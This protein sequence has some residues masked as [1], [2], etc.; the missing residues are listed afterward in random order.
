M[1]TTHL[2]R[3]AVVALAA[4][5]VALATA[6]GS[7]SAPTASTASATS[8]AAATSAS[9]SPS[10]STTATSAAAPAPGTPTRHATSAAPTQSHS[11][12]ATTPAGGVVL[13]TSAGDYGQGL[14][15]AWAARDK[16]AMGTYATPAVVAQLSAAK[17]PSKLLRTACEGDMCSW[18]NE[19]GQ[20]VTLTLDLK[21]VGAAGTHAVT[22]AKVSG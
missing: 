9:A 12:S 21:K 5:T 16:N 6:C 2:R 15:T 1:T 7:S 20:R 22:A 18:S 4:S 19:A 11:A 10:P 3:L 17:A 14:I 8:P 13:P